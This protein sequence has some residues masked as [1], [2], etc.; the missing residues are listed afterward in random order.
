VYR[1]R[2]AACFAFLILVLLAA[3]AKDPPAQVIV[4][5]SSGPPVLRFTLG[6]PKELGS[7]GGTRTYTIDITAENQW[8]KRIARA[9]FSLYLY[10]KNKVRIGDGYISI[11][12]VAPGGSIKFN[13]DAQAS[14]IPVSMDL[15]PRTLPSE[16][17][18]FLP[19]KTI[20]VTVN[21]VPQGAD[22]KIDGVEAGITPKIIQ[23]APGKHILEFAKEGFKTGDY[24]LEI[25]AEDTSGG[26]VSYELGT[27]AHDTVELRDGSVLSGDVES[28]SPTEVVV[29]IGGTLQHLSRNQVKRIALIERDAPSQ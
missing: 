18:S 25:T 7:G 5:P 24:P 17:Q 28:V 15:S 16:L 26:S 22:V 9:D 27:S 14:G 1:H 10:D 2:I 13:A 3:E 11:S 23:V 20:S 21:S 12:D 29:R 19:L 8:G 6:K 4:W